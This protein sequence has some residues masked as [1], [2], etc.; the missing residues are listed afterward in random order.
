MHTESGSS[1]LLC[2]I[3]DENHRPFSNSTLARYVLAVSDSVLMASGA[4]ELLRTRCEA[5][6]LP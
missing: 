2:C 5:K 3:P 6:Q 4:F 1:A